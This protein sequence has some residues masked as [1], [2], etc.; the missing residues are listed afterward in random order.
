M[1]KHGILGLLNYHGMT[2]YEIMQTFR[3]SLNFFWRAQTSQ[4]YR[5]LE[6]LERQG[7]VSKTLVK[8]QGKPDKNI[9]AITEAGQKELLGWLAQG[10]LLMDVRNPTLMKVFF[11]GERDKRENIERFRKLQEEC[12]RRLR[13]LEPVQGYI[14]AYGDYVEDKEKTAY[15]EMTVDYGRQNL[16]SFIDW[17]QRCIERLEGLE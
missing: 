4:I 13:T 11:L 7:W 9:F 15:W 3:D 14:Q 6:G 17:A 1:L 2:G 10:E 5:E 16:Q 12:E 8:Q